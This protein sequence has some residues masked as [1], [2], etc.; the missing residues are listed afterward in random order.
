MIMNIQ[1]YLYQVKILDTK[2]KQKQEQYKQLYESVHSVGAVRY[3]KEL[4]QTSRTG[5]A[6]EKSVIRYLEVEEEIKNETIN[7]QEIKHKIIN[8]IQELDDD[9][10]INL[11]YKKYIQFK[12][13]DVIADEM[14]YS[15]D[16]VKEL[17]RNSIKAFEEK[18]PTISHC[19]I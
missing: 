11:L 7:F 4:T 1:R 2:I 19:I 16:Y 3:D 10:F 14:N 12:N 8:E 9:R 15:Y 5:D 17:H 6:L 18:H 13:Y